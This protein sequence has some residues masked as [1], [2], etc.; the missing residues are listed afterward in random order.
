MQ[1]SFILEQKDTRGFYFRT[2]RMPT[3]RGWEVEAGRS[4]VLEQAPQGAA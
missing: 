1:R 3:G 4:R 2:E